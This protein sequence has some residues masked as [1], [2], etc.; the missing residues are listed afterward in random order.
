MEQVTFTQ[1]PEQ[2]QSLVLLS[3]LS[4]KIV[5]LQRLAQ[6]PGEPYHSAWL[7]TAIPS[8]IIYLNSVLATHQNDVEVVRNAAQ[9][10][11]ELQETLLTYLLSSRC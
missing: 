11:D 7:S 8:Y 6:N 10:K 1:Q 9:L 4:Q 2:K 5:L 3:A